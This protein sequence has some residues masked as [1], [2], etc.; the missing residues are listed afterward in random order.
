MGT[1]IKKSEEKAVT[2]M[3]VN[4]EAD[5]VHIYWRI[6]KCKTFSHKYFFN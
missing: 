5:Q 6:K 4:Q 1:S 2:R 3:C